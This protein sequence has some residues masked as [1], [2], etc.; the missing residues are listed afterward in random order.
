MRDRVYVV[1][2]NKKMYENPKYK[3]YD[4]DISFRF[5]IV[6][7]GVDVDLT[8]YTVR[9]FFDNKHNVIQKKCTV[10]D[11]IIETKLDNNILGYEGEVKVE[12]TLTKESQITTTFTIIIIVEKSINRNAAVELDPGWDII[13]DFEGEFNRKIEEVDIKIKEA[14]TKISEVTNKVSEADEKITEVDEKIVEVDNVKN[15]VTEDI[16]NKI[17]EVDEKIIEVNE[18]INKAGRDIVNAINAIPPK[19]ELIG[20]QGPV[21]PQGPKGEV[22]PAGQKGEVGPIG[23]QGP[24]G[25]FDINSVFPELPTENKTFLGAMGELFQYVSDG[26]EIIAAAITD[27][28]VTARASEHFAVLGTKI[29]NIINPITSDFHKGLAARVEGHFFLGDFLLPNLEPCGIELDAAEISD[30]DYYP[31]YAIATSEDDEKKYITIVLME[32]FIENSQYITVI[33]VD[34]NKTYQAINTTTVVTD[35]FLI[36]QGNSLFIPIVKSSRN[37]IRYFTF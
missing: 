34:A 35:D 32:S 27:R 19:E 33:L 2:I 20:A 10:R 14:N 30:V 29:L 3:Q 31:K 24:K 8:G 18:V 1:D 36:K 21:G 17:V 7:N 37:I 28:G 26:K 16:D 4:N 15:K 25:E 12:I 13:K 23:P 22:G 9:A 5:R 6:E 11:R